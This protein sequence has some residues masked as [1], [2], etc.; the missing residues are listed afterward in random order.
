M[1]PRCRRPQCGHAGRLDEATTRGLVIFYVFER[2]AQL[3]KSI[4]CS[5]RALCR[6][7]DG[8]VDETKKAMWSILLRE[9]SCCS[10]AYAKAVLSLRNCR[11]AR[12]VCSFALSGR[13]ILFFFFFFSAEKP[14]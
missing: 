3:E 6:T 12:F 13:P 8:A 1:R 10:C 2:I 4:K 5:V 9:D 14:A 7:D 11:A